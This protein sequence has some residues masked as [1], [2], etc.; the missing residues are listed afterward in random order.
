MSFE[1]HPEADSG[2][3][4]I[5]Q[6]K[7]AITAL[8][9]YFTARLVFWAVSIS[10]AVPPDEATHF[11]VSRIF[12]KVLL[13]PSDSPDS[14]QY[15]LVTH[16][17]W[18]YYWLMGKV[19]LLN[20]T[21]LPDLVFL[22]LF[23]IPFALG[24]VYFAWRTLRLLTEERLP[25]ILLVVFMTNTVMFSFLS[26]SVSYDNLANLLATLAIYSLFAFLR[27]RNGNYLALSFL[28]Q[29]AGCLTKNSMLPLLLV[30]NFVLLMAEFGNLRHLP[31]ALSSWLR[32]SGVRGG[33]LLL[34]LAIAL[35]LN[36]QLYGGNYLKY[37]NIAP[38][39]AEVLSTESAMQYR[40]QARN[41]IFT[42]FKEG[43]VSKEKALEMTSVITHE[44]DRGTT[45]ALIE[46][47]D[48]QKSNRIPPFNALEYIPIWIE[49]MCMGIFGI[50]AHLA[51]PAGGF[52]I[53][54]FLSL[55]VLSGIGFLREWRPREDGWLAGYL[56][57]VAGF[58][59]VFL[60]YYINYRTYL[61]YYATW[62]SLQ[63]RYI[64]PVLSPICV[65]ASI[66]L[67]RL[68][69]GR[70]A[71]LALFAASALLFILSDF[72]FFLANL[73]SGWFA[74]PRG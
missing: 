52:K 4:S 55:L 16:I 73:S 68:C 15:G 23:N 8:F 11:A 38:E 74:W 64:F 36:V 25:Q 61:D 53:L 35:A 57:L 37:R 46:E 44:G 7:W 67:M 41:M 17:P 22:R 71:R 30:L 66:Y 51:M 32:T 48:Y 49:T 1:Q 27:N 26:A 56:A 6:T 28:C 18:L 60:M 62:L 65:L 33:A 47:Y 12:S 2:S 39:M 31:A 54:L 70:G 10:P 42:M 5:R 19:V 43:R 13:L 45:V 34:A 29:L 72:P 59:A 9:L 20:C 69:T 3:P 50:F 24:T 58:Y 14:Y 40:T 63:G 21:G